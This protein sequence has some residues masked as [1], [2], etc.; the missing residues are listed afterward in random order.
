MYFIQE[1]DSGYIKI[2]VTE[3]LK[4]RHR[5][6]QQGNPRVLVMLAT[7]EAPG[8]VE[9]EHRLH[10]H[11]TADRV[12]GE[13]FKPSAKLMELIEAHREEQSDRG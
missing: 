12:H 4:L 2:G 1:T 8:G 6:L 7:M 3:N 11:F 9:D 13:W 5:T 10:D